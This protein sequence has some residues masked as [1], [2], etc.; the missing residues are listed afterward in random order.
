MHYSLL[1][2]AVLAISGEDARNFLQGLVTNDVLKLSPARSLY[3]AML[4]P[5]GKFLYDFFLCDDGERVL[6]EVAA[7]QAE[8][9][10]RKLGFYK[11]RSKVS[12]APT[13]LAVFACFGEGACAALKLPAAE[14]ATARTGDAIA[15][16]DPRHA[17]LGARIFA[18]ATYAQTLEAA[19][20]AAGDA[21]LYDTH[22]L[23]LGIP[24]GT[25]DLIAD[26]SFP[27]EYGFE[28][29]HAVDFAKGCYVGQ[30]V[31][32]RTKYRGVIRKS[33]YRI[34]SESAALPAAGSPIFSGEKQVGEMRSSQGPVGLALLR[35]EEWNAAQEPLLCEGTPLRAQPAPWAAIKAA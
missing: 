32:A 27:L 25:A 21:H 18:P 17:E 9:L 10:A 7:P 1:P 3:A 33:L 8:A 5:Q 20:F 14:G 29:L 19:G 30:E 12:I 31:T 15:F 34:T 23:H 22:R 24:D 28:A 11:L 35:H 4:S 13:D 2:R 26:K 16:T 6:L